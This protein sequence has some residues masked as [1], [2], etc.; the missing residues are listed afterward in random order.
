MT[1]AKPGNPITQSLSRDY[2]NMLYQAAFDYEY[3]NDDEQK[4]LI[5]F[6]NKLRKL[7]VRFHRLVRRFGIGVLCLLSFKTP[8][9]RGNPLDVSETER[10]YRLRASSPLPHTND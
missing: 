1:E 4:Q 9:Y 7:G 6:V 8:R 3:M 2:E 5:R 10:V